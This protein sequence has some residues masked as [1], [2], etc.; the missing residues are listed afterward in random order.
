MDINVILDELKAL[1]TPEHFAKLSHFGIKDSKA[2]GVKVP[3][4]RLL[5]KKIGKNHELAL[6]LWATNIHEARIL[7]SIIEDPK[8]V[9]EKQFDDWVTDFDSW[10]MCDVCVDLLA[11]TPFVF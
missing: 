8:L 10:D 3:H 2:L 9:S 7:A 5:G 4:L 6:Q 11:K 1:A